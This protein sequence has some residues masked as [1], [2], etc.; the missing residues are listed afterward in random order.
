MQPQSPVAP[1]VIVV[2]GVAASGKTKTGTALAQAL[3]WP[4]YDADD[5]HSA[6]N[7]AKMHS[8]VPLTD[9]DRKPWLSTLRTL[10]DG[11][12]TR[13]ETAVLACSA[14]KAWYRDAL[15]PQD[16][17][18]GAVRFVYL[19]VPRSTL[20]ARLAERRHFFPPSL[21][22][23]QLQTL[24]PPRDA[25]WVDGTRPPSEIVSTLRDALAV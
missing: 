12:L 24:E 1:R 19:D 8:G 6:A 17:P 5:F 25:V 2:M 7:K 11:V 18:S 3:G 21:L 22:D 4:F 13:G 15:V 23:S 16:T 10:I 9:D 14:L 20:E